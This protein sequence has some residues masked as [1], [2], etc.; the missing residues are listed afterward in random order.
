MDP[1]VSAAFRNIGLGP[2]LSL[3]ASLIAVSAA[4]VL[5]LGVIHLLYTFRGNRLHPRDAELEARMRDVPLVITRR[6]TVWKAWVG[7]NASHSFGAIF[8]GTVYAYLALA[9]GDLLLASAFL[10]SAGLV[11]LLGYGFL[12]QRYWF[13]APFRWIAVATILYA[14]ALVAIVA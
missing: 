12:C 2:M 11:L 6:T 5:L 3:P 8:F 9:H 4:V 1:M 13:R 7:F 10:L 14:A